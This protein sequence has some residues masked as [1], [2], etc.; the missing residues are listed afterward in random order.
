MDMPW[1]SPG[2]IMM[3]LFR[4]TEDNFLETPKA[5][6]FS[7]AIK[8]HFS[9][10]TDACRMTTNLLLFLMTARTAAPLTKLFSTPRSAASP[11]QQRGLRRLPD[12]GAP[13][14]ESR[15]RETTRP[16]V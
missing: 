9:G 14:L 2:K 3:N 11:M 12:A 8:W 7:I 4:A 1:A 6:A 10:V 15:E 5:I 16:R 13:E